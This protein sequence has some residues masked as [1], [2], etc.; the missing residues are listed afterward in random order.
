MV[1]SPYAPQP[2][3]PGSC[4]IMF[5]HVMSHTKVVPLLVPHCRDPF[6]HAM[7]GTVGLPVP[8]VEMRLEA[9]PELGYLPSDAKA[10]RG[11]VRSRVC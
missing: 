10:P 8:G 1:V 2:Q 11:E 7:M 4:S 9:V 3:H 6:D 5:C